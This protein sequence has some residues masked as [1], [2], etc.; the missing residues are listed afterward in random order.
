MSIGFEDRPG[1]GTEEHSGDTGSTVVACIGVERQPLGGDI[2]AENRPGVPRKRRA[3][4]FGTRQGDKGMREENSLHVMGNPIEAF[5]YGGNPGTQVGFDSFRI[6][7]RNQTA[8][9]TEGHAIGHDIR[10][11][12]APRSTR[13][14]ALG[15]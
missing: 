13:S 3:K 7:L 14:P 9:E 4:R 5:R 6:L 11:D 1:A 12:T 10:V 8:V 15:W 2:F